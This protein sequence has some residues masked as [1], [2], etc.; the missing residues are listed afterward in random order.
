MGLAVYVLVAHADAAEWGGLERLAAA[1]RRED[2]V[3]L[4]VSQVIANQSLAPHLHVAL[5]EARRPRS[6][7]DAA[8]ALVEIGL[9]LID[10]PVSGDMPIEDQGYVVPRLGRCCEKLAGRVLRFGPIGHQLPPRR[11]H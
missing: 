5:R 1:Q 8:P 6:R 9:C 4:D 3:A 10:F 7:I 11:Q 2:L